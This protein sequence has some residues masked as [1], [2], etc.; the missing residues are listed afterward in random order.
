MK[1]IIKRIIDDGIASKRALSGPVYVEKIERIA[2]EIIRSLKN[3]KK[4]IVFGNGG[5]AAD[6]QHMA[7]ELVGR[8]KKERK[9]YP[10]ISLTTNASILTAI[11]ND[12]SYDES[13]KRQIEAL[14][15]PGDIAIG[16]STSGSAK[17]VIEAVKKA[18]ESKLKTIALTGM[19]G[20]ELSKIADLSLI[21]PSKDTPRIQELHIMIIH[22]LCE[23]IEEEMAKL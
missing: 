9:G 5:S 15:V 12:Y 1:E 2:E 19:D 17:N 8:F 22:I 20:G 7:A 10:A 14:S 3:G 21:A 6:A 4:V 16:I 18:K 23:I 13:F 11:S